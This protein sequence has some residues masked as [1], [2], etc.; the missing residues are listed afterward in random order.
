M[1]RYDMMIKRSIL[2]IHLFSFQSCFELLMAFIVDIPP[3]K[4]MLVSVIV[5]GCRHAEELF[6][7]AVLCGF[8]C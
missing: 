7:W 3:I 2:I 8:W 4:P 6:F 1:L 5:V